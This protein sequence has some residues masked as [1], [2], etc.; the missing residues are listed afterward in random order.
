ME[1]FRN[2]R[3]SHQLPLHH[4]PW[5]SRGLWEERES[6]EL[7]KLRMR[8]QEYKVSEAIAQWRKLQEV[9]SQSD[10]LKGGPASTVEEKNC[11]RVRGPIQTRLS[12]R[13]E[14]FRKNTIVS[15]KDTNWIWSTSQCL[16]CNF[17]SVIERFFEVEELLIM[18]DVGV[19]VASIL[20]E[21][22]RY[23]RF[24]KCFK[25]PDAQAWSSKNW[26]TCMKRMASLMKPFVFKTVLRSC[27]LLG[28][29]RLIK[30]T[31]IGKLAHRYKQE[32]Q[33]SHVGCSRYSQC[34]Q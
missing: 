25:K 27:S 30:T 20:T 26:W 10:F 22:F 19:Q 18:S 4:R 23:D 14:P 31:S 17:R 5:A 8:F 11:W 21:E 33:E 1:Y 29:M 16:L 28:S 7:V 13:K 32:R 15:E 6:P 2:G 3:R 12:Q 24:G 9:A 34:R